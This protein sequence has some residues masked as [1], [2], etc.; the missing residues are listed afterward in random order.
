MLEVSIRI[1]VS[2]FP[3]AQVAC[4]LIFFTV[5]HYFARSPFFD[6]TS[7]NEALTTQAT[8]NA[9]MGHVIATREAFEG[10]LRTM[11]GL[12]FMVSQDPSDNGHQIEN[13]GVW[14]IRKQIRRKRQ[15]AEDEILPLRSYFVVGENIYMAP[16]VGSIINNRMVCADIGYQAYATANKTEALHRHICDQITLDCIYTTNLYALP[17]PYIPSTGPY[18]P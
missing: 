2:I 18:K 4:Q 15:G 13:S 5:L 16:F 3:Q 8:H 10:T 14:V 6:R 7:N 9:S 1:L 17:W 11:Q 12:E